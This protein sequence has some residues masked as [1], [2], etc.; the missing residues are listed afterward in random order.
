MSRRYALIL[1]STLACGTADGGGDDTGSTSGSEA[2]ASSSAMDGSSSSDPSTS[3]GPSTLTSDES[4]GSSGDASTT[5]GGMPP[6][7]GYEGYGAATQG[8]QSCDE[9]PDVVHVTSLEDAGPGT[10][11]E[12]VSAGCREIVFDLGGTITLQSD[13]NVP[14]SYVTIDGASAPEPGITIVQP[15]GVGTFIEARNSVGPVHD[16][17]IHHLRMQ[18]A[19][20][21][22]EGADI[23][24]LDG[25]NHPVSNIIIDHVTAMGA[26]DGVFDFWRDVH[27]VTISWNLVIDTV[28]M[29]HLSTNDISVTRDRISFHHNV[30]AGNNER[31]IRIRHDNADID[32]RN[33]VIYGWGWYEAGAAGLH[34]AYDDGEVNPSL[35]VVGNVFHYVSGLDGDEDDA[36]VFEQGGDVG[37]VY[38][39]GNLVPPGES[40]N[41]STGAELPVPAEAQVTLY[42]ASELG[43]R[44]VPHVGTHYPTQDELERLAEVEGAI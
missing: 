33:N 8:A 17:I 37:T 39:E 5:T 27:D 1:V 2:D 30:F 9:T 32:Y 34:I 24:G 22:E 42:D 4:S 12:A 11:R 20:T 3:G 23:W 18:G 25:E 44:V 10:L 19:S 13:L 43:E 36:I 21:E 26:Q 28:K 29:L 40:D 41:V 38:F 14:Y 6:P 15:V 31:Q 16:I 7:S 35:N